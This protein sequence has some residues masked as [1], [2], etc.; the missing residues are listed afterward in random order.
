MCKVYHW[1]LGVSWALGVI[2]MVASIVLKLLPNLERAARSYNPR[3]HT[4]GGGSLLVHFGN[5][6]GGK[7]A[8][9]F[10]TRSRATE[11]SSCKSASCIWSK[12][13]R[14]SLLRRP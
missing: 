7:N 11:Q 9:L 2:C 6:R 10:L 12:T 5:R 1:V 4:T 13:A 8:T 3:R 14:S